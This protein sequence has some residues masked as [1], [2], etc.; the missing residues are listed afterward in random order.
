MH[1]TVSPVTI[2]F[3]FSKKVE[4]V[5][6]AFSF[7]FSFFLS[8][9]YGRPFSSHDSLS[10]VDPEMSRDRH[11]KKKKITRVCACTDLAQSAGVKGLG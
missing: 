11:G 10:S 1:R 7:L 5:R 2:A 3:F 4:A 9:F 8:F 6:V